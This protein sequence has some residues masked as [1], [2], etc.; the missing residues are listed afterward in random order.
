MPSIPSMPEDYIQDLNSSVPNLTANFANDFFGPQG[1]LT[2]AALSKVAEK[3]GLEQAPTELLASMNSTTTPSS[4]S[5]S[6]AYSFGVNRRVLQSSYD[7]VAA[8]RSI[9]QKGRRPPQRTAST[10]FAQ[11]DVSAKEGFQMCENKEIGEKNSR[12]R[13]P[14]RSKSHDGLPNF[15]QLD[16]TGH[17][18]VH[19]L[20]NK[21]VEKEAVDLPKSPVKEKN[22]RRRA[23]GRS[24]SHDGLPNFA[25]LDLTSHSGV[26]K[27]QNETVDLPKLPVEEKRDVSPI[28][29]QAP[30][31]AEV[32]TPRSIRRL[33]KM[34]SDLLN[35]RK[36]NK[37]NNP[38]R[39]PETE[40]KKRLFAFGNASFRSTN[41]D[42]L[43][44]D[45][46]S[47]FD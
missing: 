35:N 25:Q 34:G 47:A 10:P 40:N 20:G 13:A 33:V 36:L 15:A 26:K 6:S 11:L 27:V 17:S 30:T 12:R 3:G 16:L 28:R 14:G 4:E 24:K 46:D 43:N 38:S 23:P 1:V 18:G 32:P 8:M 5:S 22:S 2:S 19:F 29:V 39:A 9:E 21:E 31:P 42:L 37:S 44:D 7:E 41:G 45:D